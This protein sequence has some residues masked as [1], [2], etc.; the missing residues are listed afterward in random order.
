MRMFVVFSF[1]VFVCTVK[2]EIFAGEKVGGNA[3]FGILAGLNLA[4]L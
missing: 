1:L 3:K 4:D 2:R